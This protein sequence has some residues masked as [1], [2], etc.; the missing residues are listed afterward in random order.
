[1]VS[2]SEL[3]GLEMKTFAGTKT[4]D[5]IRSQC[6]SGGHKFDDLLYRTKGDDHVK[7]VMQDGT[8]VLFNSFNGRFFGTRAN[9][10][11]FNSDTSKH[12]KTKWFSDLL[13][14]FYTTEKRS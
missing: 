5:L 6:A 4:L 12:D 10:L 7:V 3:K 14:F 11:S 9:G 13:G 1:M 2:S 8:D